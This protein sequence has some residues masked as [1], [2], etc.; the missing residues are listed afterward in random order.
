MART[1]SPNTFD[2]CLGVI[3]HERRREVLVALRKTDD[4]PTTAVVGDDER[5]GLAL[6]HNHL[7]ALAEEG[8]ID[9]DRDA[10][11]I[12]RGPR[13]DD[14]DALLELLRAHEDELPWTVV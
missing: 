11:R 9:W 3:E 5:S 14:V 6:I 4:L 12:R 10:G 13:F 7:P 2:D 8:Y 1:G